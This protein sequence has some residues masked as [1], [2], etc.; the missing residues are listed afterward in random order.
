MSSLVIALATRHSLVSSYFA[1]TQI[2][3]PCIVIQLFR[4]LHNDMRRSTLEDQ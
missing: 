3:L 4:L 1:V 2:T